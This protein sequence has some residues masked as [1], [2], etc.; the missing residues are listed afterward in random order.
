MLSKPRKIKFQA[1]TNTKVPREI[2]SVLKAVL[3]R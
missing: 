3:G 1:D 2:R